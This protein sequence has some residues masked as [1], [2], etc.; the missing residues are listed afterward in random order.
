LIWAPQS[1]HGFAHHADS[2]GLNPTHRLLSEAAAQLGEEDVAAMEASIAGFPIQLN[3]VQPGLDLHGYFSRWGDDVAA[4]QQTA[5]SDTGALT[6]N[7]KAWE[8]FQGPLR[9]RGQ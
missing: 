1:D 9:V 7:S 5:G 4:V 3:D 6:C 2:T 8:V